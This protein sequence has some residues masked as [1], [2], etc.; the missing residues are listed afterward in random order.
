MKK[1]GKKR[2]FEKMTVDAYATCTCTC[3][4]ICPSACNYTAQQYCVG[5]VPFAV[6]E[7]SINSGIT[8]QIAMNMG[9]GIHNGMNQ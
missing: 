4:S 8:G 6:P 9:S 1:L 7:Y 3:T 2:E 5:E